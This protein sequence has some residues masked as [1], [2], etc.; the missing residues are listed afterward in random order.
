MFSLL[1][2]VFFGVVLVFFRC[3]F[4]VFAAKALMSGDGFSAS[5]IWRLT[6]G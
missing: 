5:D 4:H 2:F 6:L 1:A 3:C